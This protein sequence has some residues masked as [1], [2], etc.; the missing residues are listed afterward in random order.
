MEADTDTDWHFDL[1]DRNQRFRHEDINGPAELQKNINKKDLASQRQHFRIVGED[2]EHRIAEKPYNKHH[3]DTD[4]DRHLQCPP[5]FFLHFLYF[6]ASQKISDN[7]LYGLR[8]SDR[9]HIGKVRQKAAVTLRC[10]YRR[11][12]WINN[13]QNTDLGKIVGKV[14]RAGRN[15]DF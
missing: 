13:T 3:T 12:V 11:S 2:A 9:I 14:F 7:N 10:R 6:T 15:S 4:S 8:N 1:P 5:D